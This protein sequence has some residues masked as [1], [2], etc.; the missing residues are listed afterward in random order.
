[1]LNAILSCR[2]NGIHE[3]TKWQL[4]KKLVL[5]VNAS[6]SK[7]GKCYICE[8]F[9]ELNFSPSNN[10][11]RCKECS[12]NSHDNCTN[13]LLYLP[14]GFYWMC[15]DCDD[16]EEN[17]TIFSILCR[18]RLAFQNGIIAT[19][20]KEDLLVKP[21]LFQDVMNNS[22]ENVSE[23]FVDYESETKEDDFCN[24]EDGEDFICYPQKV[25]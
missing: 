11:F 3:L 16:Q 2:L 7:T 19:N 5:A 17:K 8:K 21:D 18:L 24:E 10:V 14:K 25:H 9:Y 12:R 6:L 22:K 20:E 1:M 4:S 15:S 23:S 13:G